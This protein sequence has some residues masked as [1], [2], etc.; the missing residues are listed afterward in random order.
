MF[1][2][3]A[4]FIFAVVVVCQGAPAAATTLSILGTPT[5]SINGPILTYSSQ[6]QNTSNLIS[7]TLRLEMW[8]TEA[9]FTGAS[10]AGVQLSTSGI[11]TELNAG[12]VRT[13]TQ[14]GSFIQPP[15]GTWYLT[16]M[17]TEQ[18]GADSNQG[19]RPRVWR[20]LGSRVFQDSSQAMSVPSGLT[21]RTIS[22]TEIGLRWNKS[23]NVFGVPAAAYRIYENGTLVGTVTSTSAT[24]F[25]RT[26][27]RTNSYS[28]A[29]CDAQQLCSAQSAAVSLTTFAAGTPSVANFTGLWW[30][31]AESGWGMNVSHQ[32]NI[33]F[34]TIFTY[35]ASGEPMWLV[36]SNGAQQGTST[37]Y[38]GELYLA[39]GPAFNA[40]PFTPITA[41]NLRRV[42]TLTLNFGNS[43]SGT[44]IYD[45]DGVTV[46]KNISRQLY[47]SRTALCVATT[48]SRASL[49]NYQDLWWNP[50]ESG[51]GLNITHQDDILFATLF[52]YDLTGKGMWLVMS[53]GSLQISNGAYSGD[54]YRTRGSAFN[55]NP[56]IPLAASDLTKVGTMQLR[57]S[58]GVNGTLTYSV[59]GITVTKA[60]T[61]QTFAPSAASCSS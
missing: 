42:G 33:A 36:M 13:W 41:A 18:D 32:G 31:S 14:S 21:G 1:G 57:F 5:Y 46:T 59:N 35:D 23:T 47:G 7:G 45:V 56:F 10:V 17:W 4:R 43:F 50:S 55:A 52:T 25:D 60:I 51:W 61:R 11:L 38:S 20:N 49:T 3:L 12:F 58:D 24:V 53:N 9:P 37:V 29:A 48:A 22:P 19:Y 8:A 34:A 15:S 6:V 27:S 30:N 40:Q 39:R 16:L 54:L 28:V 2:K 44:M 26:A